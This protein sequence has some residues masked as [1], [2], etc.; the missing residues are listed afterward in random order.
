MLISAAAEGETHF[1]RYIERVT[2]FH[3]GVID[4]THAPYGVQILLAESRRSTAFQL[5]YT[6]PGALRSFLL[7]SLPSSSPGV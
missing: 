7:P 2:R 4:I 1:Q 6:K 3:G 5:V